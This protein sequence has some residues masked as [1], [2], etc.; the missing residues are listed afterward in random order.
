MR[1]LLPFVLGAALGGF[2]AHAATQPF[3][4]NHRIH[5]VANGLECETCHEGAK[6]AL[7]SGLPR[8]ELC[9]GCHEGDITTN[10]AAEPFIATLRQHAKEGKELPWVRLYQL[11]RHV[12]YS[13]RLHT[14]VAKIDCAVCHGSIGKSEVP[15]AEPVA[16]T[17]DMKNCIA[18]HEKH[19]VSTDC[20]RCHR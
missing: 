6:T 13:H 11:P 16:T 3:P 12:F 15:P 19:A 1:R 9:M 20:S 17:I 2:Q 14:T 10:K 4:F 8:V 18:C 7:H 5:T